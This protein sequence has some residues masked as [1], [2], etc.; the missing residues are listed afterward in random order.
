MALGHRART[1]RQFVLGV[2]WS[3]PRNDGEHAMNPVWSEQRLATL[4]A[5]KAAGA[6]IG[7][8]AK[9]MGVLAK[10]VDGRLRYDAMTPAQRDERRSRVRARAI[11]R[12]PDRRALH[13]KVLVDARPSDEQIKQR[14]VRMAMPYRDLTAF[15]LGDPPIGFSALDQRA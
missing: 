9:A 12:V 6:S 5:M 13:D 14:D 11:E 1:A 3:S 4:Y 15:M 10:S 7:E 2:R 8:I